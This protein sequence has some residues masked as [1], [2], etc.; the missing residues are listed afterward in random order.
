MP[1]RLAPTPSGRMHIGNACAML[2]AWLDAR[3]CGDALFLRI[4]DVDTPR[5]V[6]GADEAIMADLRWLGLDW[7]GEPVYQSQRRALYDK[8]LEQ[9]DF[10]RATYRCF[11]SRADIRAA[12]EPQGDNGF[13]VYPGTCRRAWIEE[14]EGM[15]E[16][17]RSG[18]QRSVRLMLPQ[19]GDGD[20]V[21]D[22]DDAVYGRVAVDLAREVGDPVLLRADGIVSYQLA[23]TVD[24][25]AMGVD[26]IVRGR[27]LLPSAALQSRLRSML[28]A[29]GLA[30]ELQSS[31]EFK[32]SGALPSS[33]NVAYAHLPLLDN[34][35]G[36]RLAKRSRSL[37]MG[38]LQAAGVAPERVVGLCAALL[39]LPVDGAYGDDG[40]T[41]LDPADPR[42][43]PAPLSAADALAMFRETGWN[44]LRA[45]RGDKRMPDDIAGRLAA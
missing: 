28:D 30:G 11:C 5:A 21:A 17:A 40:T 25:W 34:A 13:F 37:D 20:A 36:R 22:V 33:A 45:N 26:R 24:D 39:G 38:A 44:G 23:V 27:D 35:A 10:R 15:E 6:P 32:I 16:L 29:S 2:A 19:I 14:P 1:G 43:D 7:D 4:E 42:F 41:L 9:E 31:S 12:S 8:A 18:A 3:S